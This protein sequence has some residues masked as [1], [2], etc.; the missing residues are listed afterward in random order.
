MRKLLAI[1]VVLSFSTARA[2]EKDSATVL[3]VAAVSL[4]PAAGMTAIIVLNQNAFWRYATAVPFHISNDPPYAMHIDKFSHL[5]V[6]AIGS[7]GMRASY[8]LAGLSEGTSAW[9]GAGLSLACSFAIELEDARHGDDPQYGFSPGDLA[10]DII[11]SALPVLRHYYPVLE[12][13]ETKI[14]IWP[15]RAYKENQYK[16]IADDYESQYYWLSADLHDWTPL[17]KWLN[18]ALGFGCENLRLAKYAVPS[19]YGSPYTDL[20]LSPDINL[21]GLPI[22]GPVWKTIASILSYVRIPMPALQFYPR[23]KVWAFR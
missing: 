22:D 11:G 18:L 15:S 8:Q 5:Y 7:D 17:P 19:P 23:L 4:L 12:R 20:Y 3:S 6:S 21:K 13:I 9:L 1:F 2:Q 10:G 16:T 14:S